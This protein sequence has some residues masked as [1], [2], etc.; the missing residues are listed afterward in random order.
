MNKKYMVDVFL[1]KENKRIIRIWTDLE[2]MEKDVAHYVAFYNIYHKTAYEPLD[3]SVTL[4]AE[5]FNF[6][7]M[8]PPPRVWL[9]K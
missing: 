4:E 2:N 5:S 3:Y 9:E 7:K 1:L 6:Y 8:E